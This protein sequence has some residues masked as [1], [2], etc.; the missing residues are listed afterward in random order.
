M[1]VAAVITA[2]PASALSRQRPR[3]VL[4]AR[5]MHSIVEVVIITRG[6][7]RFDCSE[8][9]AVDYRVAMGFARTAT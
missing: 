3:T 2:E 7:E 1:T 9:T 4:N 8:M 5:S 6:V